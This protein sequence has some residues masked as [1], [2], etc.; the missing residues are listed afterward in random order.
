MTDDGQLKLQDS[1]LNTL[2]ELVEAGDRGAFH[3]IYATMT[4]NL[5]ALLTTKISTLSDV[6]GGA[7]FAFNWT[8]Q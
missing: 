7:A 3:Y 2:Q 8:F 5:D 6:V 1:E 4:H